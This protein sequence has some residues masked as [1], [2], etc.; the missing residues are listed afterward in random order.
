M[1]PLF[2]F[3]AGDFVFRPFFYRRTKE[4]WGLIPIHAFSRFG[5]HLNAPCYLVFGHIFTNISHF[6]LPGVLRRLSRG[7]PAGGLRA[8]CA[9][10][11]RHR[12]TNHSPGIH[13][14]STAIFG[15]RYIRSIYLVPGMVPVSF[16]PC[17]YK[18]ISYNNI[19]IS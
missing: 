2:E 5:R 15:T 11:N 19:L 6:C 4:I 8:C 12:T 13:Y 14:K 7:G 9:A 10:R 3:A 1:G 16:C 18:V 17:R